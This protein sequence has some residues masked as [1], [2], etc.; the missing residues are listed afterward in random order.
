M[1]CMN[2]PALGVDSKVISPWTLCYSHYLRWT[3]EAI[4]LQKQSL[5]NL[6]RGIMGLTRMHVRG[7]WASNR[8]GSCE[9]WKAMWHWIRHLTVYSR[10]AWTSGDRD[11]DERNTQS[12]IVFYF[13]IWGWNGYD[14]Y[15]LLKHEKVELL[16]NQECIHQY[17]HRYSLK[18]HDAR[19]CYDGKRWLLPTRSETV[20]VCCCWRYFLNWNKWSVLSICISIWCVPNKGH[21]SQRPWDKPGH[22]SMRVVTPEPKKKGTFSALVVNYWATTLPLCHFHSKQWHC[23]SAKD[24]DLPL[25]MTQFYLSSRRQAC[26]VC[27]LK[28]ENENY[29]ML[30]TCH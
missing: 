1:N 13:E 26:F 11:R 22:I 14:F 9:K 4:S 3:R 25:I 17:V 28:L 5:Q 23:N 20:G 18:G 16:A 7:K 19:S 29:D 12:N 24:D 6:H 10:W 2:V 27:V 30:F 8:I 15:S 21:Q